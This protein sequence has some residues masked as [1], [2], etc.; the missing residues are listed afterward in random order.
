MR[1]GEG[2][3]KSRHLRLQDHQSIISLERAEI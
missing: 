3:V 2:S 1:V